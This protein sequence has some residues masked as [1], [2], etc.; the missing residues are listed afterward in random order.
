VRCGRARA[1]AFT[2][3]RARSPGGIKRR[4]VEKRRRAGTTRGGEKKRH[5]ALCR[6]ATSAC[7]RTWR[8]AERQGTKT[9]NGHEKTFG[10]DAGGV[11]ESGSVA[12][13]SRCG[14]AG[15]YVARRV[16]SF[17]FLEKL[18]RR[19]CRMHTSFRGARGVAA[20]R[21]RERAFLS[22]RAADPF[23]R[24][25]PQHNPHVTSS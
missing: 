3:T 20:E 6:V 21:G 14:H 5:E 8:F 1:E 24:C 15:A 22:R 13:D 19:F 2:K 11:G 7:Y 23:P 16:H 18:R 10:N 25:P 4:F 12:N 9:R 17:V